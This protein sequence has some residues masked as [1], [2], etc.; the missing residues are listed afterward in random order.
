[1]TTEIKINKID[2]N[3]YNPHNQDYVK[4]SAGIDFCEIQGDRKTQQDA[5]GSITDQKFLS[6]F[7]QLDTKTKATIFNE[8]VKQLQS[9]KYEGDINNLSG[10]TLCSAI[11]WKDKENKIHI[12]CLNIGDSAAYIIILDNNDKPVM[13]QR[14]NSLHNPDPKKNQNEYNRVRKEY[15][16]KLAICNETYRLNSEL[17]LSRAIGDNFYLNYGLSHEAESHYES[18][19]LKN[20]QEAYLLVACDGLDNLS[21]K[22]IGKCVSKNTKD[23][24]LA[25]ALVKKAYEKGSGDNI[26]AA[27]FNIKQEAK[28]VF[29]ADGHGDH[30]DIISNH[31]AAN[32]PLV[33]KKTCIEVIIHG[34]SN[35]EKKNQITDFSLESDQ[36]FQFFESI[37]NNNLDENNIGFEEEKINRIYQSLAQDDKEMIFNYILFKKIKLETEE[38]LNKLKNKINLIQDFLKPNKKEENIW[39]SFFKSFSFSEKT[40]TE[41]N[42]IEKMK[43][44]LL[45]KLNDLLNSSNLSILQLYLPELMENKESLEERIENIE[46]E[47]E[48]LLEQYED[49]LQKNDFEE[50]LDLLDELII[51]LYGYSS[52]EKDHL[53][54]DK[55]SPSFNP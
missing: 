55:K 31:I 19:H 2:I 45:I 53:D 28:A 38:I 29:V 34:L 50:D 3:E 4:Q 16:N 8:T 21:R 52:I 41:K 25:F 51:K 26:S 32:F 46:K 6:Y 1:M 13:V 10:S 44:N 30:G 39:I 20:G 7:T 24:N 43:Y 23:K 9:Q 5:M 18:I 35:E 14:L 54:Q 48:I 27:I 22:K 12:D 49:F 11:A 37:I 40:S 36:N 15:K 42:L 47:L 17:A 33:F